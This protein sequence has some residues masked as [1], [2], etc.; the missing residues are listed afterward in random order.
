MWQ[1]TDQLQ[2]KDKDKIIVTNVEIAQEIL[3]QAQE[4]ECTTTMITTTTTKDN[5]SDDP[6]IG[7]DDL[8]DMDV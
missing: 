3:P 7:R 5:A 4:P 6:P 8:R 1:F 2:E